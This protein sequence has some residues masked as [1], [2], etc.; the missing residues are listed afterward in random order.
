MQ[1]TPCCLAGRP[2][3]GASPASARLHTPTLIARSAMSR[4]FSGLMSRWTMELACMKARAA[5]KGGS[6]SPATTRSRICPPARFRSSY[7]SPPGGGGAK[8]SAALRCG[9]GQEALDV[10]R[11]EWSTQPCRWWAAAGQTAGSQTAWLAALHAQESLTALLNTT[12]MQCAAR[13][14]QPTS[15][16]M[17][18]P[19]AAA[20]CALLPLPPHPQHT[21]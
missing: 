21:L 16:C 13:S 4:M 18:Q 6:T 14:P 17:W 9:G 11:Q 10:G 12:H 19:S 3:M 8:E 2:W 1:A 5:M 20:C 15:A 7:R